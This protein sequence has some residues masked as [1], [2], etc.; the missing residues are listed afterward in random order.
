MK[1]PSF[2]AFAIVGL[3]LICSGIS[4]S[5]PYEFLPIGGGKSVII[6]LQRFRTAGDLYR[7]CFEKKG[8]KFQLLYKQDVLGE[9]VKFEDLDPNEP[10]YLWPAN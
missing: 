2:F 4:A 5:E 1:K 9:N 8:L 6:P 10:I 3:F 7:F